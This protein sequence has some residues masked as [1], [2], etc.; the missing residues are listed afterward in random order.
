MQFAEYVFA[1]RK[2]VAPQPGEKG[3][4]AQFAL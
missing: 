2:F 1:G 3:L 4:I